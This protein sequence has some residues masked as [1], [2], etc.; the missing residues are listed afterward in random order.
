MRNNIITANAGD[1][2]YIKTDNVFQ[3]D[4]GLVLKIDGIQLPESYEVHFCNKSNSA[5]KTVMGDANGAAVPDEYLR[6]GEDVYAY[7]YLEEENEYGYTVY[8]IHIPVVD[9]AAIDTE[10][11]TPIQHTYVEDA[12]ATI[13]ENLEKTNQNV[14]NYPYINEHSYWMVYDADQGKFVNTGVKAKADNSNTVSI[15]DEQAHKATVTFADGADDVDL[16]ELQIEIIPIQEGSGT[17][18]PRNVR[19]ISGIAA[20]SILHNSDTYNISFADTAGTIYGGTYYPL[21][22]KLYVN[23]VFI[24]KRCVDMNNSDVQ[25][26]WRDSGIKDIVGENVD[27]VYTGQMLNI[28]TS[29]GVDTTDGKDVLYLGYDQY[30]M[31]QSEWINTEINVQICVELPEPIEYSVEQV[32]LATALGNNSFSVSNGEISYIKYPCDTKKYIDHKIAEVLALVLEN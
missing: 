7:L 24:T 28:G 27:H 26:G 22:G 32:H 5:A 4:Y 1:K 18:G 29:Y 9:R 19:R 31:R 23:K 14:L 8:N 21:L 25:P 3:Y 11:I 13:A 10:A 20:I 12:L 30:H 15:H 17:P 6:S 2:Q 16:D